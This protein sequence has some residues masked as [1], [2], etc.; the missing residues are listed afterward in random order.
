MEPLYTA[1]SLYIQHGA[2]IYSMEP[3]YTARVSAS[4]LE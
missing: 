3:L 2:S 4:S 1:W